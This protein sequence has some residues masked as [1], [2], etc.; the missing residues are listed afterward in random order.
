MDIFQLAGSHPKQNNPQ[1]QL[2]EILL[3]EQ[4]GINGQENFKSVLR[5]QP[6]QLAILYAGPTE[7]C[8]A[9]HLMVAK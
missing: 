4:T 7:V 6:K 8:D 5:R 3:M 2:T 1:R 9:V